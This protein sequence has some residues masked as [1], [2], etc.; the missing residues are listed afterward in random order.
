MLDHLRPTATGLAGVPA[1][2]LRL[3]APVFAAPIARLF[4]KSLAAG[5]VPT[6]WKTAIIS[7]I[8]KVVNYQQPSDFRPISVTPVLSP[9][10]ERLVVRHH[11]YPATMHPPPGEWDVMWV[12][13]LCGSGRYVGF[14]PG[15]SYTCCLFSG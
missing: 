5:I 1:W 11:I 12:S 6:Q 14:V 15:A 7:P 3:S 10:L 13:H 8:P 4:N 9:M 2:L